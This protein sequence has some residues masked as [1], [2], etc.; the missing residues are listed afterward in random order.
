MPYS[1]ALAL[2]IHIHLQWE[3]R[4]GATKYLLYKAH[5]NTVNILSLSYHPY[6]L[7]S[8]YLCTKNIESIEFPSN[9]N[10]SLVAL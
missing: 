8:L 1:G 3:F 6:V 10:L 4:F 5:S 9:I 2:K 7:Y